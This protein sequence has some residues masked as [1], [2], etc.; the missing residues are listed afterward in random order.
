MTAAVTAIAVAPQGATGPLRAM[1]HRLSG[2]GIRVEIVEDLGAAIELATHASE[3][4]PCLLLDLRALVSGADLEDI[5]AAT[6]DIRKACMAIPHVMPIAITG[7]ADAAIMI[8][9]IRA[10]A[11]D[12]L[13]IELE[14][15][16]GAR[17][18]LQRIHAKQLEHAHQQRT[19][20][21]L[22]AMIEDL[23]KD[24]IRTERRSIDLEE[25][26]AHFETVTGETAALPDTRP[27][28]ILL[29]EP[30]RDLAETIAGEL[31]GEGVTTFAFGSG[32]EVTRQV[33]SLMANGAGFD[34]A[35][36]AAQLEGID[37]IET[38]RKLRDRVP[39][40]PAFLM[41]SVRE[42]DLAARA[43]DL[44]V[45]GFVQKPLPD[46]GDVVTRLAQLARDAL[47]RTRG[48][49]YLQRIKARHDRVL[50]RY[51]SL[52]REP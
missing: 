15:T 50:E 30:D 52:P 2:S 4:P 22:R 51:R 16:G 7:A 14:G 35:L 38:V 27:P 21:T 20:H 36:V 18:I 43:A 23:L 11:G 34:L 28:A 6:D 1:V 48:E 42:A 13:D 49:L 32:E 29:V 8:A 41:T 33:D 31:A 24:L 40:L 10:G 39:G 19:A 3:A 17:A 5:R 37:G 9:C 46:V 44:G 25:K 47:D 45:V 26:L 12:V